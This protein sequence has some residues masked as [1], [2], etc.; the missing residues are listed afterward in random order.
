MSARAKGG[1]EGRVE[2]TSS[3]K[4]LIMT[5]A[6][7]SLPKLTKRPPSVIPFTNP[8]TCCPTSNPSTLSISLSTTFALLEGFI[9]DCLVESSIL[10]VNASTLSTTHLTMAPTSGRAVPFLKSSDESVR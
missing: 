2:L 4:S 5:L 9:L 8:R 6:V 10:L 7:T 1:K 3:N